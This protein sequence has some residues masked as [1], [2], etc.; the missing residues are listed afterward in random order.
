MDTFSSDMF[1][2]ELHMR[3]TTFVFTSLAIVVVGL[4]SQWPAL[5]AVD[6]LDLGRLV[7]DRSF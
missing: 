5:R 1:S 2:F 6:R 3:P 7:R 4:L